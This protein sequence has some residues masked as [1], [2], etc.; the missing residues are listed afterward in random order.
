M[1][2]RHLGLI[3]L[4]ATLVALIPAG[5]SAATTYNDSISGFEYWATSTQGKFTGSASGTLP[6]YWN[7]VVDHT[8]IALMATPTAT[9]TGGSVGLATSVAGVPTLVTGNFLA[10][11]TIQVLERGYGCKNQ[12]FAVT[13]ALGN[14]G[15]W[16]SGTGSGSFSAILTHYRKSVLGSCVTYSASVSGSLSD[17]F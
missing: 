6:G 8:P 14:V 7:A 17:T 3:L 5:A 1:A 13:D 2:T 12:T 10:G 16:Y 15:T 4:L 11:G 9:I